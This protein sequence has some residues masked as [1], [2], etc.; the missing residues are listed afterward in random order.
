MK[1]FK[2]V[3]K[4]L[5]CWDIGLIKLAVLT[6]TF[7][8]ISTFPTVLTFVQSVPVWIWWTLFVIS[9][10]RPFSKWFK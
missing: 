5:D 6:F 2:K 4:K 3:I 7:A 8:I 1:M 10:I 9:M